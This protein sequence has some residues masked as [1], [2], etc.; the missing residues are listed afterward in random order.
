MSMSA[1]IARA[2]IGAAF[3]SRS[4]DA[5]RML[6]TSA[7]GLSKTPGIT[8]GRT[9]TI[10]SS[11]YPQT[12]SSSLV[13]SNPQACWDW[14]SYVDHTDSYVTK[15][16]AQIRTIKAMLDA[17]TAGEKPTDV[18]PDGALGGAPAAL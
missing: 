2:R 11:L 15:S 3:I 12:R 7:R 5:S 8:P 6:T 16:G 10:S 17:L 4:M 14:W 1:T 13:P 18:P 9:L